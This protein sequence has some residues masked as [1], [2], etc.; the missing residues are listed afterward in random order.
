MQ[1]TMDLAHCAPVTPVTCNVSLLD[2]S[3]FYPLAGK[4]NWWWWWWWWGSP[5]SAHRW[6]L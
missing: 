5:S 6:Q 4:C 1:V 3:M 2:A